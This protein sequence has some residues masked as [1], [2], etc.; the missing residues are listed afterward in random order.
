VTRFF[1]PACNRVH[2]HEEQMDDPPP[3]T[4]PQ[5]GVC[6]CVCV[7]GGG[8]VQGVRDGVGWGRG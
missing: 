8:V 2:D 7:W 3:I 5:P 6:V 1:C 4:T